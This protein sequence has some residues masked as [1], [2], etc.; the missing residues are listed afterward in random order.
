MRA[1]A[2][3]DNAPSDTGQRTDPLV[4]SKVR[5][6]TFD[7]RMIAF[8][9]ERLPLGEPAADDIHR[10]FGI[11]AHDF[12][13]RLHDA[14]PDDPA[15]STVTPALR[16]TVIA[17]CRR[18]IGPTFSPAVCP[19]WQVKRTTLHPRAEIAIGCEI[20]YGS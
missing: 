14:A 16:S 12:Y 15:W 10:H 18:R 5:G 9:V 6:V 13:T 7:G 2:R 20:C 19:G 17:L 3:S 4:L 1:L 11:G 8:A